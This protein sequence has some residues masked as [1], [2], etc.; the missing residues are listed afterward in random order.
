MKARWLV[1]C[2]LMA[3]DAWAQDAVTVGIPANDVTASYISTDFVYDVESIPTIGYEAFTANAGKIRSW[4]FDLSYQ[5]HYSDQFGIVFLMKA[6]CW[7][8]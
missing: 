4:R 5:L 7:L 6:N 3:A 1:Y 8:V 2:L